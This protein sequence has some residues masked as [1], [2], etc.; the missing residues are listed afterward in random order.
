MNGL[1]KAVDR[2][3]EEVDIEIDKEMSEC[4]SWWQAKLLSERIEGKIRG[5]PNLTSLAEFEGAS[6]KYER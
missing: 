2:I 6:L 1:K 5:V 3:I 4:R